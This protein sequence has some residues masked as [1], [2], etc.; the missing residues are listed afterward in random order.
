MSNEWGCFYAKRY[1]LQKNYPVILLVDK[2]IRQSMSR[3]GNCFNKAIIENFFGLLKAESLYFQEFK[4]LENFQ[5]ELIDYTYYFNNVRIKDK[6]IGLS[7]VQYR[8][9]TA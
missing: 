2:G 3:K 9:K 1:P 4:S 8:L 7:P 6:S 5:E